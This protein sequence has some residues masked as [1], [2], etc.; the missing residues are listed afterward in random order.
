MLYKILFLLFFLPF[1]ALSQA[2]NRVTGAYAMGNGDPQGGSHMYLM[3]NHKYVIAYF[4]GAQVGKWA[5]S[6]DS[7]VLF[8]PDDDPDRFVLYGRHN[9]DLKDSLRIHFLGFYD[10]E[11]FMS[12]GQGGNSL[13]RRV[14]NPE[15]NCFSY[16]YVASFARKPGDISFSF[17][18]YRDN[19]PAAYVPTIYTFH[20]EEPQNDFIAY[21]RKEKL[22]DRPF[23]ALIRAGGLVFNGE[24]LVEKRPL[25]LKGE[26]LQLVTMLSNTVNNPLEMW[27]NPWY[28]EYM[29]DI[30]DDSNYEFNEAKGAYINKWNYKEGEEYRGEEQ[31]AYNK[32]NIIY[33]YSKVLALTKQQH[34]FRIDATP[35]FFVTCK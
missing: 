21:Y 20:H 22:D 11:T 5:I 6:G 2:D 13:L 4:G 17:L 1:A 16:P 31:D 26:D 27:T 24:R 28:N 3:D 32:M 23:V 33:P 10:D 19:R 18:P 35:L 12:T 7:I 9:K 29:Q 8:T 34:T 15:P 14:F 25:D 30:K